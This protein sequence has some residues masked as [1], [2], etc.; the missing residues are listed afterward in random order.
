MACMSSIRADPARVF[1]KRGDGLEHLEVS[2]FFAAT[3]VQLLFTG[4]SVAKLGNMYTFG[5]DIFFFDLTNWLCV[6]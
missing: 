4:S 5:C 1:E 6:L 3:S 2:A